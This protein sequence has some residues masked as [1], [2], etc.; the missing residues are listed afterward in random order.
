MQLSRGKGRGARSAPDAAAELVPARP[1]WADFVDSGG[2]QSGIVAAE[3]DACMP[4]PLSKKLRKLARRRAANAAQLAFAEEVLNG[5]ALPEEGDAV[6]RG[7]VS[8]IMCERHRRLLADPAKVDEV[9]DYAAGL[10]A[11]VCGRYAE[12]RKPLS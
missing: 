10:L 1:R 8:I 2:E 6:F 7:D 11:M 12:G 5:E 3:G 4:R 9:D